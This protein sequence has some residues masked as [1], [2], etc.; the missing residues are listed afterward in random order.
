MSLTGSAQ[1]DADIT[2]QVER[3]R[4]GMWIYSHG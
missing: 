2:Y 4:D 3:L 1:A